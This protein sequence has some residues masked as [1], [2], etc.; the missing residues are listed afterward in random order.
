MSSEEAGHS[1]SQLRALLVGMAAGSEVTRGHTG[2]I[3]PV[4]SSPTA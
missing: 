1:W 2:P 4:D 3:A